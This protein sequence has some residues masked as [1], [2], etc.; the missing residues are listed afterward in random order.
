MYLLSKCEFLIGCASAQVTSANLRKELCECELVQ[1][2]ECAL[3]GGRF[4][5]FQKFINAET[6][7]LIAFEEIIKPPY[8]LNQPSAAAG[9]WCCGD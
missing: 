1:C 2:N 6:G 5:R 4:M 9:Y 7:E 8:K 3:D